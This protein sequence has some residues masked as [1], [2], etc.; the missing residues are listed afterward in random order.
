LELPGVEQRR[1]RLGNVV[2]DPLALLLL[3]LDPLPVLP[4]PARRSRLD[5]AEDVRVTADELLVD[6]PRHGLE[7]PGLSLL[8]EQR[9][10]VRLEQKVPE[11]VLELFVVSRERG[12]GDL[13]G[14]LDRVRDDRLRRLLAIPRA[15]A[16]QALGQALEIEECV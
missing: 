13:V 6:P 1:K 7:R 15:I 10:E 9:E 16:P 12:V 5:L 3:R 11:L 4:H 8:Q 14:L 2:E